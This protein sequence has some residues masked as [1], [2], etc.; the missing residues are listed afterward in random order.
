MNAITKVNKERLVCKR[1]LKKR[2]WSSEMIDLLLPKPIVR[3]N[4]HSKKGKGEMY[5][6]EF[7]EVL[8]VENSKTVYVVSASGKLL[9]PTDRHGRVKHLLRDGKARV[10]TKKPFTIQLQY[11]STEFTQ[12]ENKT[13]K[14]QPQIQAI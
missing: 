12:H 9:E 8:K 11:P 7:D 1:E 10:I 2:G 5:Q 14:Q 4:P 3:P 6:W 13:Q